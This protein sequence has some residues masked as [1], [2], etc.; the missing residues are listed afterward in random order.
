L[1]ESCTAD[2]F[3]NL[4]VTTLSTKVGKA[5]TLFFFF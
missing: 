1:K 4:N 2:Q 3:H 5:T